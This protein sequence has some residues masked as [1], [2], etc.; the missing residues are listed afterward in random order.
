MSIAAVLQSTKLRSSATFK[1]LKVNI[2]N[3]FLYKLSADEFYCYIILFDCQLLT[4]H[5]NNIVALSYLYLS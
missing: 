3:M 4:E 5:L 1:S 2:F